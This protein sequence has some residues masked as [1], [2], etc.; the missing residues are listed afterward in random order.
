MKNFQKIALFVFLSVSMLSC[1]S[2]DGGSGPAT[3]NFEVVGIWD[4]A[5]VN[6]NTAQDV[7]MDGTPSTNLVDE[8]ACISGTLLV[9]ADLTWT[10]EQSGIVITPITNG[11]YNAQCSGTVSATGTWLANATEIKFQGSSLLGSFRIVGQTL[12]NDL[13]EDLPGVKSFVYV[14]R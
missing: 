9:D 4:L 10:Y 11:E 5:E 14:K 3:I 8:V 13:G 7:D 1:G 6:V 12:V 2:D